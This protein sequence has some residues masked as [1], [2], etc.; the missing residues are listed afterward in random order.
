MTCVIIAALQEPTP[1]HNCHNWVSVR[2][3]SAASWG[4]DWQG[5]YSYGKFLSWP[6][7]DCSVDIVNRFVIEK[8]RI[9]LFCIYWLWILNVPFRILA[10]GDRKI[11][12]RV[13]IVKFCNLEKV[14]RPFL[15][16]YTL[17]ISKKNMLTF[18]SAS[19]FQTHEYSIKDSWLSACQDLTFLGF[20]VA[21]F[22]EAF[23]MSPQSRL[24]GA[25][26]ISCFHEKFQSRK[27]SQFLC[28]NTGP[29]I[30]SLSLFNFINVYCGEE[31]CISSTMSSSISFLCQQDFHL[32]WEPSVPR[33]SRLETEDNNLGHCFSP[34]LR[35]TFAARQPWLG[36]RVKWSNV[37]SLGRFQYLQIYRK[38]HA[39]GSKYTC[40]VK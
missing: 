40:L 18:K 38:T 26:A 20:P 14:T 27:K 35:V 13:W 11:W 12:Q 7:Y 15:T 29:P 17:R 3:I 4:G 5:L 8:G 37:T 31:I 36:Y 16:Q 6:N 10:K 33:L 30:W 24:R 28:S 32:I 22:S 21:I 34:L 2:N 1:S 39:A 23:E 25:A 19:W 9:Q